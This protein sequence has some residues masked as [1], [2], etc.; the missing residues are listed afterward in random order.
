MPKQPE[1]NALMLMAM[2]NQ[3]GR[4]REFPAPRPTRKV[5]ARINSPAKC[6]CVTGGTGFCKRHRVYVDDIGGKDR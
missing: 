1:V 2:L 5:R 4:G 3:G 6:I